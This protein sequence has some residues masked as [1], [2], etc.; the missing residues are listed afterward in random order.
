MKKIWSM[1]GLGFVLC[2][3]LIGLAAL[4]IAVGC[5]S[6]PIQD[7]AVS[8][9][10]QR[11]D[12]RKNQSVTF[13]A[14]GAVRYEWTLGEISNGVSDTAGPWGILSATTGEEVTYT[15][16][17]QPAETEEVS[18]EDEDLNRVIRTITVTGTM[19][20]T[21]SSNGTARTA[22]ATAYIYHIR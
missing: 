16:L 13:S 4:V 2:G 15:S 22:S 9:S 1:T 3:S 10:P 21:G 19:G 6:E 5:D 17:R 8:I 18:E 14:T 12:V 20:L 7:F 11:V